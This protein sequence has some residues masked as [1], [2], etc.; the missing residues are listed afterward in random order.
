MDT[1]ADQTV[2]IEDGDMLDL[3]ELEADPGLQFIEDMLHL[4]LQLLN[5]EHSGLMME[6]D[7]TLEP[8]QY[9]ALPDY[10]SQ[11]TDEYMDYVNMATPLLEADEYMSDTDDE[12]ALIEDLRVCQEESV[13]MLIESMGQQAVV[14]PPSV[15]QVGCVVDFRMAHGFVQRVLAFDTDE[16]SMNAIKCL[17]GIGIRIGDTT[18]DG[19]MT[20]LQAAATE[21]HVLATGFLLNLGSDIEAK[22]K[23][24]RTALHLAAIN[25]HTDVVR[26]LLYRGAD[27]EAVDI[28][29]QTPLHLAAYRGYD[30]TVGVLLEAGVNVDAMELDGMMALHLAASYGCLEVLKV[31]LDH[32]VAVDSGNKFQ[33]TALHIA[34]NRGYWEIVEAL[35]EMGADIRLTNSAQETALHY[36]VDC[37]DQETIQLLLDR[38]VDFRVICHDGLTALRLAEIRESTEAVETIKKFIDDASI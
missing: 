21:G 6:E 10:P 7:S 30:E 24:G 33:E 35:L 11:Y 14:Q 17:L 26:V 25:G 2:I 28:A 27:M 34:A 23:Y 18:E 4:E 20:M 36:A 31:M 29:Q 22:E 38:G 3:M 15:V 1:W 19:G 8:H 32:G 9:L 13:Q 37:E 12:E 5:I 16:S